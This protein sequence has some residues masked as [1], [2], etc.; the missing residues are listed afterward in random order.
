MS[1]SDESLVADHRN[2]YKVDKW[3]RD[4]QRVERM[5]FAGSPPL[6]VRMRAVIEAAPYIHPKLSAPT[7]GRDDFATM[8]ERASNRARM[9]G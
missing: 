7:V 5:L 4:G 8:L 1:W 9:R 6:S 2:F 3:S